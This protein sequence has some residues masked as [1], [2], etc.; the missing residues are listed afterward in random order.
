MNKDEFQRAAFER[1]LEGNRMSFGDI[2]RLGLNV[3]LDPFRLIFTLMPG[4]SGYALR[5]L[6]Y[7]ILFKDIAEI[8]GPNYIAIQGNFEIY[9]K[10]ENKLFEL[11]PENRFYTVT[12][13]TTTEAAINTNLFRDLYIVIGDGSIENG[14]IVRIYYNPLVIWIWIGV[15]IVFIGGIV[16][17][18]KN[19]NLSKR[20][21]YE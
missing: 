18:I 6:G 19:I 10:K 12:K 3:F 9:D 20:Q 17:F 8:K 11:L 15:S 4:P 1:M 13:N 16:T 7:K 21:I 5:R 14:W 2:Y